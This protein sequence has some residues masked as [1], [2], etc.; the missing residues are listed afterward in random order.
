LQVS[1]AGFA[2]PPYGSS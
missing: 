2:N 1:T